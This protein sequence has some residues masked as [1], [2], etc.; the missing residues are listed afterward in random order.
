MGR[1]VFWLGSF[2]LTGACLST[3]GC[4]KPPATGSSTAPAKTGAAPK[5]ADGRPALLKA[6]EKAAVKKLEVTLL[7][8]ARAKESTKTPPA[9][10]GYVVLRYRVKNTGTDEADGDLSRDLQWLNASNGMRNG[11]ESMTGVKVQNPENARLA[12]GAEAEFEAVYKAPAGLTELEFHCVQGYDP[13]EKA[14]WTI[15]VP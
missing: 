13:V 9:G 3:A 12:P 5:K 2:L 14:R 7:K 10:E 8:A 4:D 6:G 11:P 1:G 15:A